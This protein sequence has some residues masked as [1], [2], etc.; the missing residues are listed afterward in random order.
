MATSD[1]ALRLLRD[2]R[3][4]QGLTPVEL[5]AKTHV[6]VTTILYIESGRQT[7]NVIMAQRIAEALG[8]TVYD[9]RW[10]KPGELVPRGAKAQTDNGVEN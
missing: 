9:I 7:P 2:V 6:S 5:A 10:P 3:E 8:V 4:E 1:E